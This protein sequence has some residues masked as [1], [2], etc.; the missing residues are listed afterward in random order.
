MGLVC[1]VE[2]FFFF[3]FVIHTRNE[4][5]FGRVELNEEYVYEEAEIPVEI[6]GILLGLTRGL[7]LLFFIYCISTSK[8]TVDLARNKKEEKTTNMRAG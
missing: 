1:K 6:N 8:N 4:R 2:D 3:F 7:C 5:T